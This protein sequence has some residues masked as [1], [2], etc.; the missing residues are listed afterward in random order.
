[1][2][3]TLGYWYHDFL[4]PRISILQRHSDAPL[5]GTSLPQT[6]PVER[7]ISNSPPQDSLDI[8][9]P[10]LETI[11]T[12]NRP[13]NDPQ[14]LSM[15]K[16]PVIN[17]LSQPTPLSSK[18][19]LKPSEPNITQPPHASEDKPAKALAPTKNRPDSNLSPASV[20]QQPSK[21]TPVVPEIAPL[22]TTKA[23]QKEPLKS[24]ASPQ[25]TKEAIPIKTESTQS[26]TSLEEI[27]RDLSDEEVE[28][29][30]QALEVPTAD[31]SSITEP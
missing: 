28:E 10:L 15:Q 20:T 2:S 18:P 13:K 29:L 23:T 6:M 5:Q 27:N 22:A 8:E 17:S 25:P 24:P 7:D 26:A 16:E 14:P 30:L 4:D 3:G 19:D 9:E 21:I 1:V 12:V 31:L 11:E